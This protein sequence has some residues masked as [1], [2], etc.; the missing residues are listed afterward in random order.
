[1]QLSSWLGEFRQRVRIARRKGRRTQ[2]QITA[3][4][5]ETKTLLTVTGVLIGTELSV[6]VDG[7]DSVAEIGRAHV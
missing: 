7:N 6:F 2:A 5:L 3:E 4:M 1:M